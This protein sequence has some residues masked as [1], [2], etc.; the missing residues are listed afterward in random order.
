MMPVSR[1]TVSSVIF[2]FTCCNS[3]GLY[4][5]SGVSCQTRS[6]DDLGPTF[7]SPIRRK[8]HREDH[9]QQ[10]RTQPCG[11]VDNDRS[12]VPMGCTA[13]RCARMA[14]SSV[15]GPM[16][17]RD[18]VLHTALARPFG[19]R[20]FCGH[21]DP[22]LRPWAGIGCPFGTDGA[23]A[24][25]AFGTD[26]A[27]AWRASGTDGA[28]AWR[29]FGTDGAMAWRAFGTDGAMAATTLPSL[30]PFPSFQFC[31]CLRL[32]TS[33]FP[34]LVL[35]ASSVRMVPHRSI[36]STYSGGCLVT[37]HGESLE[38]ADP[39]RGVFHLPNRLHTLYYTTG[40]SSSFARRGWS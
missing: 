12:S 7:G 20:G 6:Q 34:Y 38:S 3:V 4:Q 36:V 26:G 9:A 39:I 10:S 1:R 11:H 24:W 22:G 33:H 15:I 23:M 17:T 29:A 19:T 32:R 13:T 16:P 25:R 21:R 27:M 18:F 2:K 30:H 37:C 28:M 8:R 14:M 35:D 5:A 40:V 31:D